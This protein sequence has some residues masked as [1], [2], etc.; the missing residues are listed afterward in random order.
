MDSIPTVYSTTRAVVR[1]KPRELTPVPLV[2]CDHYDEFLC[3]KVDLYI[4]HIKSDHCQRFFRRLERDFIAYILPKVSP[5]EVKDYCQENPDLN[6]K[7]A[8]FMYHAGLP[9][10]ADKGITVAQARLATF[11]DAG[12]PRFCRAQFLLDEEIYRSGY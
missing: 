3:T 5:Q 6:M 8:R 4:D 10:F 11:D 1:P 12:T 2:C 9:L 7:L